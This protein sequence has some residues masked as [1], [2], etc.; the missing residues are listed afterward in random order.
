MHLLV[1]MLS[2]RSLP[3]KTSVRGLLSEAAAKPR[4][5][6][7]EGRPPAPV[8]QFSEHELMLKD[9]GQLLFYFL[10]FPFFS[11]FIL[12]TKKTLNFYFQNHCLE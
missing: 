1:P 8:T 12:S 5:V 9:T 4:H 7:A 6:D 10:I 3:L 11:N 2:L